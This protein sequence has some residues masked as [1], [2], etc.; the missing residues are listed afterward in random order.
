MNPTCMLWNWFG[1]KEPAGPLP[2]YWQSYLQRFRTSYEKHRPVS[3]VHFVV[4]DT[5]TTGLDT[6]SDQILSFGAVGVHNWEIEAAGAFECY[7]HQVYEPVA[8]SVSVHGILPVEREDSMEEGQALEAFLE[9]IGDSVLVGHNLRFDLALINQ[10]LK[11]RVGGKLKNYAVDTISLARRL[12]PPFH[13]P[14]PGE[15]SLDQLCRE[16]RIPL[17]DRHTAAGDAYITAVLFL[18]LL[19]RLEVRGVDQLGKL[20]KR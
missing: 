16:Y 12:R 2:A 14:R 7:V 3:E 11:S 4:L 9:F 1:K 19:A 17:S 6:R 10:A 15:Y 18:K 13:H 5:E 20:L 8:E